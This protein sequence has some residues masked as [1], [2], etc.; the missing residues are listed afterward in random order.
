MKSYIIVGWKQAQGTYEGREY[1]N[2]NLYC[3]VKDTDDPYLHLLSCEQLKVKASRWQE[4]T[5]LETPDRLCNQELQF[6]FDSKGVL[7]MITKKSN[8]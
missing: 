7:S 5:K 3:N 4:I 2:Y 6:Y 8:N 1:N